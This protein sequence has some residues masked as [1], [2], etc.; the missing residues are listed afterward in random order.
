PIFTGMYKPCKEGSIPYPKPKPQVNVGEMTPPPVRYMGKYSNYFPPDPQHPLPRELATEEDPEGAAR[1]AVG[2]VVPAPAP[3]AP[4]VP[5]TYCSPPTAGG[6][7]AESV[8]TAQAPAPAGPKLGMIDVIRM[9]QQH[10]DDQVII[11]QIRS[12]GSHF[13]L[14]QADLDLLMFNGVSQ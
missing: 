8:A 14:S 12:T 9:A 5:M 13:Q 6:V 1:R 10:F 7:Q 3:P 11:N 4:P 2:G